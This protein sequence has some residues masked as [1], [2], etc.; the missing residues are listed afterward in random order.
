MKVAL[1]ARVSTDDQRDAGTIQTQLAYARS[2]AALEDWTLCEFL[3]DGVSGTAPLSKRPAGA[4]LLAAIARGELAMVVTY[5]LSRLGRTQRIVLEAVDAFKAAK[6]PYRSLTEAFEIGTPFGDATL[7]M[8]SVFAQLDRDSLVQRTTEGLRRVAREGRF[9]GGRV[10]YGYRTED[11]RLVIDEPHALVVRRIHE[12][13]AAGRSIEAVCRALEADAVPSP[14]GAARWSSAVVWKFLHCGAYLGSWH[15]GVIAID[16][17]ALVSAAERDSAIAGIRDH[18]RWAL[19]HAKREYHLRGLLRCACGSSMSG[20]SYWSNRARTSRRAA[21]RCERHRGTGAGYLREHVLL[22]ALWTK[23]LELLTNPSEALLERLAV[24]GPEAQEAA[25]E[26]ELA[27]W[28]RRLSELTTREE[29]LADGALAAF[30]PDVVASRVAG[31]QA[32]RAEA[33]RKLGTLREQRAAVAQKVASVAALRTRILALAEAARGADEPTRVQ[34]LRK[35]LR[36]VTVERT[37]KAVRLR[38]SWGVSMPPA[39][40]PSRWT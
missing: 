28:S 39:P 10:P 36:S 1:Y 23:A 3:D 26:R 14:S 6:I 21:Y 13:A 31:L 5:S 17:P 15:W 38:V 35:M 2:R 30:S 18:Q 29:R 7:G 33:E 16:V 9:P 24:R 40:S 25:L 37:G 32:E 8:M 20:L 11:G 27:R 34:V 4:A 12:L 22:P 19:A